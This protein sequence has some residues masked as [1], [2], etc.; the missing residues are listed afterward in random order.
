MKKH[1]LSLPLLLLV[2][3]GKPPPPSGPPMDAPM[4]VVLARVVKKTIEERLPLV[5]SLANKE[6][7]SLVSEVDG[8][9]TECTFTEG[10]PVTEGQ[11]LFRIDDRR[12]RARLAEAKA[13]LDLAK[14]ELVRGEALAK[15]N[16]LPEQELDRLKV[17]QRTTE[18]AVDLIQAELDDTVIKAPFAGVIAERLVSKGQ[19]VARGAELAQLG[20]ADPLEVAF[21][22]PERYAAR[23]SLG[24]AIQMDSVAHAGEKFIGKVS[25]LAPLM[26]AA[27]RTLLVKADIANKEGRLRPGMFGSVELV[28]ASDEEGLVIPESSIYY[29]GDATFVT[30]IDDQR[31]ASIRPVT[32]SQ[33]IAGQAKISEGL[34]EGDLVIAEGFQKVIPGGKVIAL[35]ASSKYGVEPDGAPAQESKAEEKKP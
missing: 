8:R 29:Q 24:Q 23:V 15:Q 16:S 1:L 19:F 10:A 31:T 9:V 30:A 14:A 26:D 22:V 35:A 25:Y 6:A 4:P 13:R 3:C 18:A 28:F 2:G 20:Q 12:Q 32:I 21:Q 7:V 5:G 34:K 11:I 33:R 27:S 17:S